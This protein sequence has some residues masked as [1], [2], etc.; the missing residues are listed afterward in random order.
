[1]KKKHLFLT[2][3]SLLVVGGGVLMPL[4]AD[5]KG[6]ITVNPIFEVNS[7]PS[8]PLSYID[9]VYQ[10]NRTTDGFKNLT[11]NWWM[12]SQESLPYY[13]LK[14]SSLDFSS[15]NYSSDF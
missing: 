3:I 1:M 2:L 14:A 12:K 15:T 7:F 9:G 4:H 8:A 5:V 13:K 10:W 6:I 11:N